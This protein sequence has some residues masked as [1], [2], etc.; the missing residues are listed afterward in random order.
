M[1]LDV[2]GISAR[3]QALLKTDYLNSLGKPETKNLEAV[4]QFERLAEGYGKYLTT[5]TPEVLRALNLVA[6]KELLQSGNYDHI[7]KG[8]Q[9]LS[10]RFYLSS[11]WASVHYGKEAFVK[12]TVEDIVKWIAYKG[13]KIRTSRTQPTS[14]VKQDS[15]LLAERITTAIIRRGYAPKRFG[16]K[17]SHFLDQVITQESLTDLSELMGELGALSVAYDILQVVPIDKKIQ[18]GN[19]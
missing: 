2:K 8:N 12:P 7:I 6:S 14:E 5:K 11:H 18:L 17:G 10:L 16:A 9:S 13:I 4:T 15:R 3:Q 1:S 19:K